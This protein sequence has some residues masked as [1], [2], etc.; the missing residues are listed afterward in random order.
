MQALKQLLTRGLFFLLLLTASVGGVAGWQAW[1]WWQRASAPVVGELCS[2]TKRFRV[3]PGTPAQ[4]IGEDLAAAGLIRSPQ[5]WRLWTL[6]MS[7]QNPDGGFQAGTYELSPSQPLGEIAEQIWQGRVAQVSFTIPEGWSQQQMAEHFESL[8]YFSAEDFLAAT[9][10]IPQQRYPWLPQ[11][12]PHLEGF[13]YPDTYTLLRDRLSPEQVIAV[14][15]E[16]FEKVAL[17]LYQQQQNQTDLSLLEWVTLASIVEK[18]SVVAEERS[19]IAGVFTNRLRQGMRLEADP[20]VEYA[21]GI[22]Q[23]PDQPL[24]LNQVRTPSP[25]NTYLNSGLPPTPIASAGK[26]SLAATLNPAQTDYLFFVA[27]YDGTHIFSET[28][29]EHTKA[30][31][32]IRREQNE[33]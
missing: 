1:I 18:E 13:L 29:A 2:P 24:T 3:P 28:L 17:P 14:M 22:T 25:Y 19:L 30:Q 31:Q 8:G 20:T 10:T 4:E 21:L 16:R 27:R 6:W 12:L 11:G 15:L 7:Q 26:A 33:R 5:A 23:T 9:Q 32:A